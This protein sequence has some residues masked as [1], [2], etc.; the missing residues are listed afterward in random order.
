MK[1]C[2][3][4]P[5][6][7]GVCV[8]RHLVSRHSWQADPPSSPSRRHRGGWVDRPGGGVALL[9]GGLA[10]VSLRSHL[11]K[12]YTGCRYW[13]SSPGA[14]G[15]LATRVA[16]LIAAVAPVGCWPRL[17]DC[18][19]VHLISA[20]VCGSFPPLVFRDGLRSFPPCAS[21]SCCGLGSST[22][23]PVRKVSSSSS[24]TVGNHEYISSEFFGD[25]SFILMFYGECHRNPLPRE[26]HHLI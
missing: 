21:A 8:R 19:D 10:S 4:S 9:A 18:F 25:F 16:F 23:S 22:L 11:G 24:A 20:S 2:L 14:T 15:G 6:G 5:H 26:R 13:L 17:V 1:L 7:H 12:R 3:V